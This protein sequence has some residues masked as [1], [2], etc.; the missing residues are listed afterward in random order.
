M[1]HVK[2]VATAI[3]LSAVMFNSCTCEKDVPPVP[4][5]SIKGTTPGFHAAE[6]NKT[7]VQKVQAPTA[8]PPQPQEVAVA[9]TPT[10]AVEVPKDF[11][12][13]LLWQFRLTSLGGHSVLLAT[14][15]LVFGAWSER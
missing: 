7:P 9:A 2:G 10:V 8:T 11:P 15:G 3:L 12:A 6:A 13:T 5:A 4:G 1:G 14:L